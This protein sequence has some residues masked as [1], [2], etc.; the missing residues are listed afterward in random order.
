MSR[1]ACKI[2]IDPKGYH[3]V[4]EGDYS[5]ADGVRYETSLML[6]GRS[7]DDVRADYR[8]EGSAGMPGDT[9]D[10]FVVEPAL[11]QI[12]ARLL[13]PTPDKILAFAHKY[14]SIR[15]AVDVLERSDA[16]SLYDWSTR[17]GRIYTALVSVEH[18]IHPKPPRKR[19]IEPRTI[20]ELLEE[21]EMGVAELMAGCTTTPSGI[22][23]EIVGFDLLGALH[24]QLMD[25]ICQRKQYR[26]CGHCG[27]PFELAPEFNRSDRLYCSDNCRVKS[28]YRR[29]KRAIAMRAAGKT[30]R[31]IA[32]EVGSD[33]PTVKK[34][35][36]SKGG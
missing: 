1:F 6:Y 15:T 28:A 17:I 21:N 29:K 34:W 16:G 4:N 20:V 12:F 8:R 14:G 3:W 7:E 31:E 18:Y 22:E 24:L 35:V 32:K 10:P 19:R 33:V 25:C 36:S 27:R 9:Y 23:L 2:P 26:D 11:F 13:P 30:L 5:P